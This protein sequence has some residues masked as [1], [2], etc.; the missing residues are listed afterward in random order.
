MNQKYYT[1]SGVCDKEQIKKF[2]AFSTYTIYSGKI[3]SNWF[4]F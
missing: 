3:K 1:R 2:E 4:R